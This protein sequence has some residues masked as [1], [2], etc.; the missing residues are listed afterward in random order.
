MI[1]GLPNWI[2]IVFVFTSLG[3]IG[4]FYYSNG[5][6]KKLTLLIILWSIVHSVLAF[7]GFYQNTESIPPRFGLVLIPATLFIIFGLLPKQQKWLTKKR[8]TKIS[9]FLHFVRLPVEIVLF[10]L[11]IH[12]MVPELMTFNGRN[13]DI[14]VGITA[15]IVGYLFIVGKIGKKA[16]LIWNII[17]LILVLFI[18]TN[19]LLSADLPFQQ[20]G[21]DQ[22]NRGINYFPFVLLPA[23]IVPI[24]IWTHL[25]DIIILNKEIR[26][27][28]K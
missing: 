13:F 2:E 5:K 18:L 17:G 27:G 8:R 10:E 19:G 25:S 9:T 4:F 28:I 3:T 6:P 12:K 16:L 14:L 21:F 1:E 23:L 26:E 11:F 20:F 15:P 24:V 7:N 22:P